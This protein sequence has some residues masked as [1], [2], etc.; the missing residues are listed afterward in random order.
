MF[1]TASSSGNHEKKCTKST[2]LVYNHK[3]SGT[4]QVSIQGTRESTYI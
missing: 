3:A 2:K 1:R 4:K